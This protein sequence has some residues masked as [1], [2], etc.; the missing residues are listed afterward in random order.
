M[1]ERTAAELYA[2]WR[3]KVKSFEEA[4]TRYLT[5]RG[6]CSPHP[7]LEVPERAL[8]PEALDELDRLEK[9]AEEAERAWRLAE[10]NR[11]LAG[12]SA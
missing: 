3:S 9:E 12:P 11:Y 7:Q 5:T 10:P 4:Q 6:L 1:T 8:T 2:A